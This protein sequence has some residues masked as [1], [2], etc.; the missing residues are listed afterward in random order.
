MVS[1]VDLVG[2]WLV[3]LGDLGL[4]LLFFALSH[5][6]AEVSSNESLLDGKVDD[7]FWLAAD[8]LL[9]VVLDDDRQV[10]RHVDLLGA[11]DALFP[12]VAHR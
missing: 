2:V 11:V 8:D 9:R 1:L 3:D 6:V 7:V 10:F 12:H 4:V 5:E